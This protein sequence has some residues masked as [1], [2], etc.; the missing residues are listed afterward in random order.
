MISSSKLNQYWTDIYFH[1][2][3]PHGEK[4]THQVVRILQLIDKNDRVVVNDVAAYLGISHNTASEHVKRMIHKNYIEK[5]R[6]QNDERKVILQL[7]DFGGNVLHENTSLD[8]KKLDHIFSEMDEV[9]KELISKAFKLLS[10][11]AK[12]CM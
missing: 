5:K 4:I 9:E 1:L 3:Y 6:D 10:E 7:T 11:R 12:S 2:H 8:E